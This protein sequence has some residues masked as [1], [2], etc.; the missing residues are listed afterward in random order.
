MLKINKHFGFTLSEVLITLGIIGVVSAMTIPSLVKNYQRQVYVTQL[1]KVYNEVG[2]AVQAYMTDNRLVSMSE[3]RLV[4]NQAEMVNFVNTYFK[5]AKDCGTRYYQAGSPC[6]AEIYTSLD[7]TATVNLTERQCMKVITTPSGAALCFD[8]GNMNDA[9]VNED[10]NGDG[11]ID[12]NDKLHSSNAI[13]D[14]TMVIAV[15]VDINGPAGPN[16]SG[17]DYFSMQV[18]SDGMVYERNW[19]DDS[20]IDPSKASPMGIG[21]I[22]DDGWEM[23]Y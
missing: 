2:Q 19:G 21:K 18:R 4:G 17:R 15:E 22:I 9:V 20:A 12:E 14:G 6:F 11:K 1:R 7:D 16:I 10:V 23:T 5:T 3:S 8:A 13:Y